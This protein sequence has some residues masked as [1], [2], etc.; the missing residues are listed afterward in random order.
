[1]KLVEEHCCVWKVGEID[2]PKEEHINWL[3]NSNGHPWKPTGRERG[4][5]W[6]WLGHYQS[7]LLEEVKV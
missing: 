4:A 6:F 2:F 7:Q 1:M 3:Y 5:R